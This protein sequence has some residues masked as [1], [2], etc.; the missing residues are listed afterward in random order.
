VFADA[1]GG[2][3]QSKSGQYFKVIDLEAVNLEVVD[4]EGGRCDGS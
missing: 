3:G 4:R 2:H 1:L